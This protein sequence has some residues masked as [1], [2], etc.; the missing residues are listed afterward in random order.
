MGKRVFFL[1]IIFM[2]LVFTNIGM[3]G[4]NEVTE[5]P[6]P[7]DNNFYVSVIIVNGERHYIND[8]APTHFTIEVSEKTTEVSVA[9]EPSSP[10]AIVAGIG[11]MYAV[12]TGSNYFPFT[13]TAEN[14]VS[15]DYTLEIIVAEEIIEEEIVE[16][17]SSELELEITESVPWGYEVEYVYRGSGILICTYNWVNASAKNLSDD[18][19]ISCTVNGRAVPSNMSYNENDVGNGSVAIFCGQMPGKDFVTNYTN[20]GSDVYRTVSYPKMVFEISVTDNNTGETKKVTHTCS[21]YTAPSAYDAY[22]K[23]RNANWASFE[24]QFLSY[25]ETYKVDQKVDQN[26]VAIADNVEKIE[27]IQKLVTDLELQVKGIACKVNELES[28]VAE[29][30]QILLSFSDN[31]AEDPELEYIDLWYREKVEEESSSVT[32]LFLSTVYAAESDWNYMRIDSVN[33]DYTLHLDNSKEYNVCWEATYADG[34]KEA[35]DY[36]VSSAEEEL[37]TETTIKD[38]PYNITKTI[39]EDTS[40]N[41]NDTT[42]ADTVT[43]AGISQQTLIIIVVLVFLLGG[44]AGIAGYMFGSGKIHL[45]KPAEEKDDTNDAEDKNA[46]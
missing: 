29:M 14:G 27:G 18:Y 37:F 24:M 44:V 16:E 17:P 33:T 38:A 42:D 2:T 36:L 21:A 41:I 31:F 4:A 3:V 12:T 43:Q 6:Q 9:V 34:T 46:I 10:T 32:K 40:Y 8:T 39:V 13:I 22:Y 25:M 30:R 28:D 11:G 20:V 35:I 15:T 26:T 19:T 23:Y 5:E 45:K 1:I 7:L